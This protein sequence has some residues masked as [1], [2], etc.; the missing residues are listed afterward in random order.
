MTPPECFSNPRQRREVQWELL[1]DSNQ[2]TITYTSGPTPPPPPPQ[3]QQ[4]RQQQQQRRLLIAI[5][6]GYDKYATMLTHTAHV[7][8]LYAS[9]INQQRNRTV[10]VS[11]VVLQGMAFDPHREAS[12]SSSL[13][14]SCTPPPMQT[15]LN[16]IR[17]LF[18]AIDHARTSYDQ[19]LLLDA[20]ALLVNWDYDISRLLILPDYNDTLTPPLVVAQPCRFQRERTRR[21]E[22][23]NASIPQK[24]PY[25]INTGITLWNLHHPY[26]KPVAIAWFEE[27]K[28]AA[29]KGIYQG[30]QR[31]LQMALAHGRGEVVVVTDGDIT[32]T[33]TTI[34]DKPIEIQH[35]THEFN[36]RDGTVIQHFLPQQ[37]QRVTKDTWKD[38][39]DQLIQ[40][41][42]HLCAQ[43]DCSQVPR[44]DYPT[45]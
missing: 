44:K 8:K 38:R 9:R 35:T 43:Y 24:E 37:Q 28:N 21:G 33:R 14:S 31:Y 10:T 29:L 45:E 42:Q 25:K 16:K 20:D 13:S 32:T 1:D 41:Y 36:Y 27:S 30:D 7:A 3:K 15:T 12:S 18:Y 22:G 5:T 4:Q 6:S 26:I 34:D 23:T 39:V 17:L 40:A 2:T 19:L 11:V